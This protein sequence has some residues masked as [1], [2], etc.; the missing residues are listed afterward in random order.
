MKRISVYLS[1]DEI[2]CILTSLESMP[3]VDHPR[4]ESL[5]KEEIERN[6][7]VFHVNEQDYEQSL[8]DA[9]K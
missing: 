3:W 2:K 5:F 8:K 1:V 4:L 9:E 7:E 6:E